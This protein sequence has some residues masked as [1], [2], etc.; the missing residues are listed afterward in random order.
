M[1]HR[2]DDRRIPI[3]YL[4][5]WVDFGGSDVGTI[6]WF[7]WIDRNR[8]VPSLITTQPSPNRCLNALSAYADEIWSLPDLLTGPQFPDFIL[9]FIHS[10]GIEVVHIMNSRLGFDLLPDIRRLPRPPIVV[11]QLHVEEPDRSGYV[12][13]V[14]TRYGNLVD[15]FSVTNEQVARAVTEYGV[16]ASRR[17]IIY[18][19][20]DAATTFSPDRVRPIASF[21]SGLTHVLFPAR[22]VD[23]KDPL[24]MVEVARGLAAVGE[25]IRIHCVGDGPL[26][27]QVR[28]ALRRAHLEQSVVLHGAQQEMPRWYAAMDAVLLTSVFEGIPYVVY[29]A[30]AMGVPCVVPALPG[31]VE[32]LG[33]DYPL[34]VSPRDRAEGY[35]AALRQLSRNPARGAELGGGLRQR[36]LERF[37]LATMGRAHSDLY[38]DLLARRGSPRDHNGRARGGLTEPLAL[39]SR[40]PYGDPLVSIIIPCFNHGAYLDECLDSVAAQSYPNIE[41]IIVDDASTDPLTLDAL[42][43]V[44]RERRV[45]VLRLDR[46]RGPGAARNVALGAIRG[47]FVLPLDADNMLLPDAVES[48]VRQLQVAGERV[49]FIYP[50]QQFFGNRVDHFE[51]PLYNLHTL[52]KVNFCDTCSLIDADVFVEGLRY[53]DDDRLVHE[54]WDF[55]LQLA[56][57][58]IVGEPAR[59]RTLLSRLEGVSR[60]NLVDRGA[61]GAQ[62]V[63]RDRHP[64][65]FDDE[66]TIK[67]RW[68]PGL[69]VV[70]LSPICELSEARR[71]LLSG[72]AAQS[73]GDAE[74][75]LQDDTPW[76]D[77]RSGVRVRRVPV[78]LWSGPAQAAAEGLNMT[79]GRYLCVH[80]GDALDLFD[81]PAFVEKI[82][83]SMELDGTP[84]GLVDAGD[85]EVVPFRVLA[86]SPDPEACVAVVWRASEPPRG[87]TADVED[88]SVVPALVRALMLAG[89]LRGRHLPCASPAGPGASSHGRRQQLCL[90]GRL[91]TAK[92]RWERER[93]M[94]Q[95]PLLPGLAG[96][97]RPRN[98]GA[99][100]RPPMTSVLR[101]YVEPASG[102][103][104]AGTGATGPPGYVL[105]R[106]LGSLRWFPLPG[107]VPLIQAPGHRYRVGDEVPL[108]GEVMLGHLEAAALPLLDHVFVAVHRATGQEVLISGEED[109]LRSEVADLRHLGLIE[110]H[111]I[112]PRYGEPTVAERIL[113][114]M[115]S[116]EQDIVRLR[117][118]VDDLE[119]VRGRL[120]RIE[121]SRLARIYRRVR[122]I[123]GV[124]AVVL[125][126]ARRDR[127]T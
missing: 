73:C 34:L 2:A 64:D 53:I 56:E 114:V 43:L 119:A 33:S 47:R 11:V 118:A 12:R 122:A 108:D 113:A 50:N 76:P 55:A 99:Q 37:S 65:L 19:G 94:Q 81:D 77:L 70:L 13:Y 16:P 52:L 82:L 42:E 78:G 44:D 20:V 103:R 112:R 98:G 102:L 32:L 125:G 75:I 68:S 84:V 29:E 72:L 21:E 45:T 1:V 88:G 111:P 46:N 35:V 101:R 127:G 86:E 6:D 36:A 117:A 25:G 62:Q 121:A 93:R 60:S 15:A 71:R 51:A 110:P 124:R 17:T 97:L 10:R 67:A 8:F 83:R 109:P 23:Q 26:A 69:S 87:D 39:R 54:D 58:G 92:G 96:E 24:L 74:V 61:E 18:T 41:V 40:P 9:D 4:A 59:Q 22:L 104:Y 91:P 95:P 80:A 105:E 14:T 107:T 7:K 115:G 3:L 30:M 57:R 85:P 89:P 31:C 116:R 63:I 5:P 79:R 90:D 120:A 100:W 126:A 123:P 27:E 66:A 48:L 28:T 106:E 49:G 38:E